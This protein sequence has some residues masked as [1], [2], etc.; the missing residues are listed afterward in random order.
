[1]S[2]QAILD[3]ANRVVTI[4]NWEHAVG[5]PCQPDTPLGFIW[6]GTDFVPDIEVV[7]RELKAAVQ[8][9][10]DATVQARNY[11]GIMSCC[12]Y[13]SSTDPAFAAEGT[14]ALAWRDAVWRHCYQVLADHQAGL[15]PVPTADELIAE[16]PALIW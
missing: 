14:A 4:N 12:T 10:M 13:H 5:I 1:M 8:A 6:N 2:W 3:D 11:D 7:K 15:R 16:L 9:H